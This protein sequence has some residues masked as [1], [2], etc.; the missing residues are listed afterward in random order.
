MKCRLFSRATQIITP[1]FLNLGVS[2][3][4]DN[5]RGTVWESH[6]DTKLMAT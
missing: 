1:D 3:L 5:A 2:S 4:P 6:A